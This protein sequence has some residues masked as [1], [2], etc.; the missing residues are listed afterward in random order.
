[1]EPRSQF[2]DVDGV[3]LHVADWGGSGADILLVHANGF[4]GL[5]YRELIRHL[6][7]GYHVYTLDLRGQGDS[8]KPALREGHWQD[9]ANDVEVVIDAL[10]L[11]DFYGLGHSGGAALLAGYTAAH[12][13][14][15]KS[16][17]LLEPVT[18]P[19]EPPFLERLSTTDHPL[20]EMT[21]RRRAVWDSRQQLF[22]AY[23]T[24]AAF[25]GWQKEVLWDYINHGTANLPNGQI[26]LK[27][28]VT[29]EAHVFAQA[30]LIDIYSQLG[31]VDC[32]AIVLRGENTDPP[33]SLVAEKVAQKIPQGILVTVP[34][35][36]HF[37]PMEKPDEIARIIRQ[38]FKSDGA[39]PTDFSVDER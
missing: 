3:K 31:L 7:D 21:L 34:D 12:T 4:L 9:M 38:H 26:Q 37:L 28:P 10:H 11:Q 20:V 24:K 19:H 32:P 18:F 29:V 30:P 22:D 15:V 27:C 2:I 5:V 23:Q 6:G 13:G 36:S 1:M 25:S 14:R 8:D 16:L 33:L 35:T 17:A 39:S